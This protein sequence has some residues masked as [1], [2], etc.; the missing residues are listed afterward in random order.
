MKKTKKTIL[1]KACGKGGGGIIPGVI[2][3]KRKIN[4]P[5]GKPKSVELNPLDKARALISN[6][7]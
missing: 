6:Y 3:P 2:L 4:P 1:K 5:P 7:K